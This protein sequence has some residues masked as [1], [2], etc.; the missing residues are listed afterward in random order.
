MKSMALISCNEST[1]ITCFIS[2][3]LSQHK[4][5]ESLGAGRWYFGFG[6]QMYSVIFLW[7]GWNLYICAYWPACE[8]L[9]YLEMTF[10]IVPHTNKHTNTHSQWFISTS[11]LHSW[12]ESF[13]SCMS[14]LDALRMRRMITQIVTFS[15]AECCHEFFLSHSRHVL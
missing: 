4:T 3:T 13:I 1:M 7:A 5:C 6:A 14:F 9:Y 15:V 10:Y 2:H 11:T 8:G 12:S